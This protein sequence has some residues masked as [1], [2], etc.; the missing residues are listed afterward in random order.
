MSPIPCSSTTT[1][2]GSPSGAKT[3]AVDASA[4]TRRPPATTGGAGSPHGDGRRPR[5]GCR[6]LVVGAAGEQGRACQH[7]GRARREHGEPDAS[8]PSEERLLRPRRGPRLR[9][10]VDVGVDEQ[11][12]Q[13]GRVARALVGVVA[14]LNIARTRARTSA[15]ARAA[16]RP[17][18]Q[19]LDVVDVVE[20]SLATVPAGSTSPSCGRRSGRRRSAWCGP[21][22]S[23]GDVRPSTRG[24]STG[25]VRQP[26]PPAGRASP[27]RAPP[28]ASRAGGLD[29]TSSPGS[30]SCT[31]ASAATACSEGANST[32]GTGQDA[33]QL[34][35][36]AQAAARGGSAGDAPRR[37]SSGSTLPREGARAHQRR[38]SGRQLLRLHLWPVISPRP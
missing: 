16:P 11:L 36:V 17:R 5:G 20:R 32:A 30:R 37:S 26:G 22:R 34:A 8:A 7:R 28:T 9:G 4:P 10:G 18:A 19:L 33:A 27:S 3:Q 35:R 1:R 25:H 21:R 23:L 13:D 38:R 29:R 31:S 14:C 24:A 12:A 6:R 2:R 15:T